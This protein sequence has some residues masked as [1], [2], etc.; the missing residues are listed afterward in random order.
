ME[1][2][3]WRSC[4]KA[5]PTKQNFLLIGVLVLSLSFPSYQFLQM[6]Y[7]IRQ[8]E[9]EV[10]AQQQQVEHQQKLLNV[11]QKKMQYESFTPQ[12]T[13]ALSPINQHIQLTS[14]QLIIHSSQ[15]S[16]LQSPILK[17]QIQGRFSTINR[18][19]IQL[20]Q[21]FK[22]LQLTTLHLYKKDDEPGIYSQLTCQLHH[23]EPE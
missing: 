22:P 2:Q 1:Q 13:L 12:L 20:L 8:L 10:F 4:V 3:L 23:K 15:W 6:Q 21:K 18:F 16:F 11:L 19:L 7:R 14:K 5:S 17:L 9:Q